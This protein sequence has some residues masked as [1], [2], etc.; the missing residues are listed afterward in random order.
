MTER[1]VVCSTWEAIAEHMNTEVRNLFRIHTAAL[2]ILE[3]EETG[4]VIS[5]RTGKIKIK[6]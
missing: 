5:A 4:L 6:I 1:Y 3:K 2:K